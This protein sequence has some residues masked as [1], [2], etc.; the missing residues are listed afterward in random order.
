MRTPRHLEKG[1]T[2]VEFLVVGMTL[3]LP[4]CFAMFF[5]AQILWIWHSVAEMTREGARYA[6]THCYQNGANVRNYMQRSAPAMPDRDQFINGAA[7]IA[8]TY[9]GR[10]AESNE[11]TE[12]SCDTECS[13]GCI[14]DV[15]KVQVRNYEYRNFLI[16]WG[17]PPVQLPDFQTTL[18]MEGAGCDPDT[19]SC[20][21]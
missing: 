17:I 14:P 1:A 9:Y 2:A 18:A 5:T 3:V 4:L 21:P 19:G 20:N 7:E 15:V 12:F 8:V 16:Y 6:A 11:L 10:S 13:L